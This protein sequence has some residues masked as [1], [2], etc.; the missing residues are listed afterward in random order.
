MPE[1]KNI[2]SVNNKAVSGTSLHFGWVRRFVQWCFV[3]FSILLGLQFRNFVLS[4]KDTVDQL[5]SLRPPAVEGYLP[6]SSLMSLV[7]FAKTGIANRVHPAGLVV[8]TLTLVLALLIRRGFCSWVCPF[9]TAAEYAHQIGKG[10]F[11]G[12]LSMPK[13]PDSIL[14]LLKYA[15]LGF[16]LY[17]IL[18][19]PVPALRNFIYGSYNRIADIKMYLF[20]SNISLLA[21]GIIIVIGL[22]SLFFKNFLCRYLCPYGA[23]LGIFSAFSP[24][25]IRRNFN[26][27]INCGKCSQA[28]PNR[29]P[30]DA[31]KAVHS[32]ECTACFDCVKACEVKDAIMLSGPGGKPLISIV[33]YGIIT[34]AVFFFAAQI[35]RAFDYWQSETSVQLYRDLYH[36]IDETEHP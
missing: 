24:V 27:C 1:E 26:K 6:I 11:G 20:F 25:S 31:K 5:A 13:W 21:A 9:G 14:R 34:V 28:C 2:H 33:T 3:I 22:L 16:F 29:I 17:H 30:V 15:L 8:F 10:M 4:L 7:Y 32:T 35:A 36:I 23:L 19:M 12:N 18:P